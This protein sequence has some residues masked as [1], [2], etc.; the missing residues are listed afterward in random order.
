MIRNSSVGIHIRMCTGV[1]YRCFSGDVRWCRTDGILASVFRYRCELDD[2]LGQQGDRCL[3]GFEQSGDGVNT[4]GRMPFL[5]GRGWSV[6]GIILRL[7][8]VFN[9]DLDF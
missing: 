7:T 3:G 9:Y 8:N 5:L 4:P 6:P 1:R 2:A